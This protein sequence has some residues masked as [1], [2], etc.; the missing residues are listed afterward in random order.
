MSNQAPGSAHPQSSF[1]PC[2]REAP[3]ADGMI[4]TAS[5]AKTLTKTEVSTALDGTVYKIGLNPEYSIRLHYLHRQLSQ[6]FRTVWIR[7]ALPLLERVVKANFRTNKVPF[8]E[9][10]PGLTSYMQHMKVIID[11]D[12]VEL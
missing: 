6:R 7:R 3:E 1:R 11:K 12:R 4:P 5:R 2:L 9:A 8:F 10:N